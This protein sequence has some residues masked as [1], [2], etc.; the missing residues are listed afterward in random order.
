V[1][2]GI[3]VLQPASLKL[4]A[5]WE[6]A[7][8]KARPDVIVVCAYGK[9]LPKD[10]L[11]FPKL[12]CVN[13][14]A[15]LLPKYRG[16]APIHRAVEAGETESGV[17]L[18]YMSE[19]M[20]EGDMIA[21]RAIPI[22]GMNSGDATEALARL[23]ADLL[24]DELPHIIGCTAR[25]EPQDEEYAT[26]APPILKEEGLIDFTQSSEAVVNKV[27]A[28]TPLPGAYAFLR[29]EK[30][31]V[32]E[33]RVPGGIVSGKSGPV[34]AGEITGIGGVI[35]VAAGQGG[36]IEITK[37]QSPG[38]K[39]MNSADWLRGHGVEPG[40]SFEKRGV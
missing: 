22:T 10:T 33:A 3:D 21:S 30:I 6:S 16:A 19:G 39:A 4:N 12:G 25:R 5:E 7:L 1:D 26:Y 28:M 31:K 18:M 14:H 37:V 38:G 29:G 20:D 11:D 35:R 40:E 23:G 32:W 2:L 27:L 13:I 8:A 17:T 9:I 15:S 36:A 34:R 24:S